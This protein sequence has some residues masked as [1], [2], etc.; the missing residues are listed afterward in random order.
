MSGVV[1]A[2]RSVAGARL[3]SRGRAHPAVGARDWRNDDT[4]SATAEPTRRRRRVSGGRRPAAP[5]GRTAVAAPALSLTGQAF[6]LAVALDEGQRRL[7]RVAASLLAGL[8]AFLAVHLLVRHRQAEVADARWLAEYEEE[9]FDNVP[10]AHGPTWADRRDA[11]FVGGPFR[12]LR[13][14][15][16]FVLWQYTLGL[17]GLTALGALVLAVVDR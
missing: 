16:A 1:G 14:L 3:G 2:A 4:S 17:F 5:V 13:Q 7:V 11:T 9:R 8:V 15:P 6:L 10:R 12:A